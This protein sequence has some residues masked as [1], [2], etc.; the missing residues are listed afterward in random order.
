MFPRSFVLL[1]SLVKALKFVWTH[2]LLLKMGC[3]RDS[4]GGCLQCPLKEVRNCKRPVVPRKS[5]SD[6]AFDLYIANFSFQQ[7]DSFENN[8]V[9]LSTSTI[10]LMWGREMEVKD[11]PPVQ[12]ENGNNYMIFLDQVRPV[13]YLDLKNPYPSRTEGLFE[14]RLANVVMFSYFSYFGL[15][16]TVPEGRQTVSVSRPRGLKSSTEIELDS[17]T[18]KMQRL[19]RNR[20]G[21]GESDVSIIYKIKVAPQ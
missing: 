5:N 1:R 9:R 16:A 3:K 13:L 15:R 18:V 4:L 7:A 10:K 6:N 12:L 20:P 19:S 21:W 11:T 14:Q 2:L 8:C 17:C